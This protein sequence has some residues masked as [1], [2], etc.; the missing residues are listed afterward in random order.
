MINDQVQIPLGQILKARALRQDLTEFCMRVFHPALLAAPHRI[1]V[2]DAC[3]LETVAAGFQSIRI[4]EFS[5]SV[6][7]DRFKDDAEGHRTEAVFNAVKHCPDSSF[8]T[9]VQEIGE[10]EFFIPEIEGEDAL[11]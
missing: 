9:A 6:C 11:L 5:A 7:Q 2:I 3:S 4:A 8:G 1:T 10:E